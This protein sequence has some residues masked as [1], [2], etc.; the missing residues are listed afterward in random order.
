MQQYTDCL[1]VEIAFT[2]SKPIRNAKIGGVMENLGYLLQDGHWDF[3]NWR[4]NDWET[5]A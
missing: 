2:P 1:L 4:R 3:Q 5:E